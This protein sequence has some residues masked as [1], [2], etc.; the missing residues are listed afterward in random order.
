MDPNR[1]REP[2]LIEG[3][4]LDDDEVDLEPRSRLADVELTPGGDGL[5]RSL[6]VQVVLRSR[7]VLHQVAQ[8]VLAEQDYDVAP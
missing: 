5:T 2:A 1:P 6:G 8:L 7:K 4:F 3:G